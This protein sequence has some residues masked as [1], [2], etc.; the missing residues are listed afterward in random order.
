MTPDQPSIRLRRILGDVPVIPVLEIANQADA[1][2]LAASLIEG[3][4]HV[5]EVTLRTEAALPAIEGV[6]AM[7]G[8]VVGAGSIL[9]QAHVAQ[10][11]SAGAAFGVSPGSSA[12]V[13]EACRIEE[14]PLLPGAASATEIM[15]LLD[16][17]F[18]FMKFFPAEA[19]GG[20][21]ALKALSGPL[22]SVRFCP[23]G[24]I[25]PANAGDYLAL[26][27]VV[28]VG[29]SWVAPKDAVLDRKWDDIRRLASE[30]RALRTSKE[31]I[32]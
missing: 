26:N 13:I 11:K 1:E 7:A 6:A 25:G 15:A 20:H 24:G 9:N 31:Q 18:D 16:Q 8:C 14:L 12:E 21:R 5:I 4:L 29:G 28:C 2:P 19:I 10:A 17:G 3:G 22:P 27:N 23:T 32:R 30:A